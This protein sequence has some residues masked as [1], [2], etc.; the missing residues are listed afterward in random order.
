MRRWRKATWALVDFNALMVGLLVAGIVA[1]ARTT[2]NCYSLDQQ[3]CD[4]VWTYDLGR[5]VIAFIG[6]WFVGFVVLSL[7]W[8][9]S[10]PARRECPR[11]GSEVTRGGT[12]CA[13][14]HL[15][16]AATWPATVASASVR[17]AV[18]RPDGSYWSADGRYRW[19]G[20]EWV[21]AAP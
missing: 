17:G 10:R 21:E 11:C 8:L 2:K 9:M 7:V 6:F 3:T 18:M 15:D 4:A 16:F 1:A 19:T 13:H 12:V 5:V 20:S 14:C